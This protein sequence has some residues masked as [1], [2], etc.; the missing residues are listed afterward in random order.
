MGADPA[1]ET[2]YIFLILIMDIVQ[3]Q[4]SHD[5]ILHLTSAH[6]VETNLIKSCYI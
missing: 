1:S 6:T 2:T 3:R 5:E 4:Y